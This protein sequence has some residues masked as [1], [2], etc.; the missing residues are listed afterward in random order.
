MSQR[1]VL[2]RPADERGVGQGNPELILKMEYPGVKV[3]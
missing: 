2:T 3:C 1:D